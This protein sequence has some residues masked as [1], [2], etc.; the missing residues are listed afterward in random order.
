[1]TAFADTDHYDNGL[2]CLWQAMLWRLQLDLSSLQDQCAWF[3]VYCACCSDSDRQSRYKDGSLSYLE[4][5][6]CTIQYSWL[7]PSLQESWSPKPHRHLWCFLAR[8]GLGQ[9]Q[10]NMSRSNKHKNTPQRDQRR[11]AKQEPI[12]E[13][14]LS[15]TEALQKFPFLHD[16]DLQFLGRPCLKDIKH[17]Q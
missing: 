7:F 6:E 5:R 9:P 17:R 11:S 3:I 4:N 16:R 13:Q 14:R 15:Y 12:R 1:M 2:E 10:Y 8:V